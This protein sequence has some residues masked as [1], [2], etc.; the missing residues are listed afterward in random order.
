MAVICASAFVTALHGIHQHE[1]D[2]LETKNRLSYDK[3][4]T[5]RIINLPE[6]M[7]YDLLGRV[8]SMRVFST[9]ILPNSF[10]GF[11]AL[12]LPAFLGMQLDR[13]FR[14]PRGKRRFSLFVTALLLGPTLLAFYFTKSKG[15]APGA[16]DR[17]G[18]LRRMGAQTPLHSPLAAH[19]RGG[20]HPCG[21]PAGRPEHWPAAAAARLRRLL[22]R[23][24]RILA[25]GR[26]HGAEGPTIAGIGLDN[27]ADGYA[28]IKRASD[29]E[30]R[31]RTTTMCRSRRRSASSDFCSMFW[32]GLFLAPH[33][34]ET[35]RAHIA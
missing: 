22:R 5:L 28:Q 26:C 25:R 10:A 8:E 14:Q 4:T 19:A 31:R 7:A 6:E 11:L 30:A 9:F 17:A 16:G 3:E 12:I 21:M 27:F 15:S 1:I 32:V 24:H 33:R 29:Q 34:A 2:L 23:A 13:L 18:G 20:V 35:R